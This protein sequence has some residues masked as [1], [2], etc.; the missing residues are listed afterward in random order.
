MKTKQLHRREFIQKSLVSAG[1]LC[2]PGTFTSCRSGAKRN[3]N[4]IGL[5]VL[6][7]AK[8]LRQ[9]WKSTLQKIAEIGYKNL[10]LGQHLGESQ[11]EF[12]EFLATLG[13][14]PLVGG[15]DMTNLKTRLP[16]LLESA[17]EMGKKY[18]VCYW[19]WMDSASDKTLD[20]W[21]KVA[22]SLNEIGMQVKN[23][24]MQFV[25]H[26]HDIEFKVTDGEIPYD[27]LLGHTDSAL[28]GMEIDLYWIQ[29]GGQSPIP[30][31]QKYPGRFPLWHV[32]DM[33]GD[34]A[35][36]MVCVGQGI[37]DFP[38]IFAQADVSG[39]KYVFVEHDR[40]DDGIE[41]A[42]VSYEYLS[43]LRY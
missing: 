23:A 12:L 24:G 13:L 38:A 30:Y 26:N 3:L 36:S 14:K 9:D 28:V 27:T 43:R 18:F 7:I 10:E 4:E 11:Q 25:Y 39:M 41:C 8:E 5:Q 33:A 21:K 29:K 31:F 20:D 16:E 2:L 35:Q 32:K 40:P 22:E 17:V 19:P 42:R 1:L 37:L 34:D 15:A 6:T